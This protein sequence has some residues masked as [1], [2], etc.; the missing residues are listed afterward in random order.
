M[1]QKT[2]EGDCEEDSPFVR[3]E[4]K[5]FGPRNE[6]VVMVRRTRVLR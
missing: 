3:V 1:A 4:E 2:L 6:E 5:R